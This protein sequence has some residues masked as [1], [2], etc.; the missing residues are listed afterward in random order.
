ML[1]GQVF[2]HLDGGLFGL[3][4][5]TSQDFPKYLKFSKFVTH[6]L[7]RRNNLT[8]VYSLKLTFRG[9]ASQAV[10]KRI[11]NYAF[12]RNIQQLDVVCLLENDMEFPLSLFTS[13]SLK[14]LSLRMLNDRSCVYRF[15]NSYLSLTWELPSLTTLDLHSVTLRD[16]NAGIGFLSKCA[17]LKNLTLRHIKTTGSNGLSI[18]HPQL[19][20]I[21]LEDTHYYKVK[22][23][24]VVAPQL[25]NALHVVLSTPHL[26]SLF[27][28]GYRPLRLSTDSLHSLEK[29][30]ICVSDPEDANAHQI[31]CLLQQL[32]NVHSLTL[33]LEIA[34]VLYNSI[35]Q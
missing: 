22:V 7:S 16:D 31:V 13:Q 11:L 8:E 6:V 25:Q 33:N 29:A 1:L 30:N 34:E 35:L 32:H 9:K 5:F 12:S 28:N 19:S 4:K 2:C 15:Y 14:H 26:T 3:Q 17:N 21:T 18:C 10:V 23:V 27:D 24:T 20:N